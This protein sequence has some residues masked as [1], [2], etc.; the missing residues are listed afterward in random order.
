MQE[1]RMP[2]DQPDDDWETPDRED[3]KWQARVL[4][5]VLDQD[6]HQLSK[7]EISREL[8]GEKPGFEQRDAY[9]RAVEDLCCGGLLQRCESLILLTRAARLF[10]S[11][12]L[13]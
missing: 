9:E 10:A 11:L 3:A 13:D 8:L 4:A 1:D 12:E 6:P 7:H 2:G 5:I